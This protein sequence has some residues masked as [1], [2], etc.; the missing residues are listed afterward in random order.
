MPGDIYNITDGLTRIKQPVLSPGYKTS[1][2]FISQTY[3]SEF[4]I[5][6]DNSE[7]GMVP[8]G[9]LTFANLLS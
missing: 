4:L 3:F 1:S 2:G 7:P 9:W 6:P 5:K 8:I